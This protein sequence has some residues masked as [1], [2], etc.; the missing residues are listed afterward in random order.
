[1]HLSLDDLE[2]VTRALESADRVCDACA[3]AL[4]AVRP[5]A[6]AFCFATRGADASE[7]GP[8][9]IYAKGARVSVA[10]TAAESR[11]GYAFDPAR[12][13]A[14]QRRRWVDPI[15]EGLVTPARWRR[16]PV[17][18]MLAS[19]GVTAF[20]RYVACDGPR[21]MG[22]LGIGWGAAEPSLS[23]AERRALERIA[24]ATELPLRAA[25]RAGDGVAEGP[26]DA[27]L[28]R[29]S[30]RQRELCLLLGQGMTNAQIGR[31][32]KISPATVKTMLER[33]FREVGAGGRVALL[34]WL[35]GEPL[36]ASG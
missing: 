17:G 18:A 8:V 1:M 26:E 10:P 30:P 20:V 5:R 33:L 24:R 36:L 22:M 12:V 25:V 4:A 35:R 14:D 11:K 16:T 21:M 31:R 7:L 29:L 23:A 9:V 27:R 2:L 6:L 13:P 34:R 28:A 32:M 15:A 3:R 19:F